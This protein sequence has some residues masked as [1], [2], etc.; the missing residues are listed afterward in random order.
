MCGTSGAPIDYEHLIPPEQREFR[1]FLYNTIA[2]RLGE[3]RDPY[4]GPMTVPTRDNQLMRMGRGIM[5]SMYERKGE[6]SWI[7][8]VPKPLS[9]EAGGGVM[10]PEGYI[11][12][13]WKGLGDLIGVPNDTG[14][15][16]S[17]SQPQQQKYLPTGLFKDS[18]PTPSY[19][20]TGWDDDVRGLV[21]AEDIWRRSE[22]WPGHTLWSP[23]VGWQNYNDVQQMYKSGGSIG[24]LTPYWTAADYYKSR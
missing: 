8:Q 12:P 1:K 5:G 13:Q 3:R 4:S 18:A 6:P 19:Q 20:W 17:Q 22:K 10:H 9:Y 21:G 23:Q 15:Y 24:D 16:E 2:P 7:K 11:T 14:A